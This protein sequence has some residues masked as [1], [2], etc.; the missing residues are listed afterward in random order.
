MGTKKES[1]VGTSSKKSHINLK[2]FLVTYILLM[3]SFFL[4]IGLTPIQRIVDLN[5]LYTKG[6]VFL[7]TE[8]LNLVDIASIR[9]GS[10][11][12]LP[13]ISLDIRFGCNGL[14]AVLIYTVSVIAFPS[15]WRNRL[16]GIFLGFLVIQIVN[17]L[18]IVGLA[19][20]G[21]HFREFFEYIHIYVAQ[22]MMIAVSLGVFFLYL[23]WI[24]EEKRS[25][26][27]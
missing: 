11:I 6:V 17:I 21:I 1:K 10:I 24:N 2:R 4:L 12:H 20:T 16:Y 27:A 19:Y 26:K 14:E 5:G 8:V 3:G 22:G 15:S 25:E 7:T 9:D 23:S 18:R 13:G